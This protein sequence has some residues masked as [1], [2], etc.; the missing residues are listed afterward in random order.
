MV[1][2][3]KDGT[4]LEPLVDVFVFDEDKFGPNGYGVVQEILCIA[5][6]YKME[7][8]SDE[9]QKAI[10]TTCDT[11]FPTEMVNP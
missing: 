6:H 10:C 4:R 3:P 7:I 5:E 11:T 1:C 8:V 9:S 2:C